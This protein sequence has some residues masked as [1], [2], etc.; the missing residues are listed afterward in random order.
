MMSRSDWRVIGIVVAVISV[1][2]ACAGS[3]Y[4]NRVYY[5]TK[6]DP[7]VYF[8]LSGKNCPHGPH[9]FD[10]ATLPSFNGYWE[11][12]PNCPEVN[13]SGG[14]EYGP[15]G[16]LHGK[17]VNV[18]KRRRFHGDGGSINYP[19]DHVTFQGH[20]LRNNPARAKGWFE[21]VETNGGAS[22][23]TG[24]VYWSVKLYK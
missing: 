15:F 12:F 13:L 8:Y 22:C 10:H 21:M 18:S 16:D 23:D 14:F 20:F 9:C 11:Q 4:A 5:S 3:A 17:T 1:A 24:R 6:A 19:G 7:G 2:L